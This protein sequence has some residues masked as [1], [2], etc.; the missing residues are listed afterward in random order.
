MILLQ[1]AGYLASQADVTDDSV[2][3]YE[4]IDGKF[5]VESR[6]AEAGEG[7]T[8]VTP[9]R[10]TDFYFTW[11]DFTKPLAAKASAVVE[12][13]VLSVVKEG[14]NIVISWPAAATG[15]TLEQAGALPATA[16]TPVPGVANN[17][18]TL[19]PSQ[20]AGFYRLRN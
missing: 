14:A 19:T 5:I 16:W 15:F 12:S 9:L 4:F 3:A 17:R 20:A 13:P 7:G 8:D 11:V 2:L 1:N 10:D 18:V 6:H